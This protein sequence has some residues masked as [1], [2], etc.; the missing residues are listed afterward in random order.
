MR[1][2]PA[3]TAATT[4]APAPAPAAPARRARTVVDDHL[5]ELG[6][7]L[8]ALRTH[9]PRFASW[10][11]ELAGRLRRGQRLLAAGNG[12]SAAEAQHLTAELVGRYRGEREPLSAIALHA[13]TSTMTALGN[14]YGFTEIYARQVR[15]HGRP[16]DVLVLL[17]TSGRSENLLAAAEVARSLGV[18]VWSVTGADPNPLAQASDEAICLPGATPSV[19]EAHLVAVHLLCEMVDAALGRSVVQEPGGAR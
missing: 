2:R 19:Q 5:D 17:S 7:T 6:V 10:G 12:G 8:A 11:T 18:T 3:V 1:G 14:D 15:A 16:G 13:D 4:T 9:A